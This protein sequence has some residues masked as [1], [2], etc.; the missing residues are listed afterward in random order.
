MFSWAISR[1][2]ISWKPKLSTVF[3]VVFV[4]SNRISGE[5]VSISLA[6]RHFGY[7][8]YLNGIVQ[9]AIVSNG[10]KFNDSWLYIRTHFH[11]K[12]S[13][14]RQRSQRRWVQIRNSCNQW[15]NIKWQLTIYTNSFSPEKQLFQTKATEKMTES[16]SFKKM[17]TRPI[18][19]EN[20]GSGNLPSVSATS[21][22]RNH[23]VEIQILNFYKY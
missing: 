6:N 11:L 12:Y 21:W 7:N 1:I 17:T 14:F 8:C 5:N 20:T 13:Y 4:W 19:R 23:F 9:I 2:V 18:A 15:V 16:S 10:L 3:S 22:C